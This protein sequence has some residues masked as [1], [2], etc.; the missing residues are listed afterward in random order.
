MIDFRRAVLITATIIF[1]GVLYLGLNWIPIIGPLAVGFI[2]GY[3]IKEKPSTGFKAGVYSAAL[4]VIT[5]AVVFSRT[6]LFNPAETGMLTALLTTWILVIWNVV[7]ILI[8]GLGGLL[9]S[10]AGQAKRMFEG[11]T[12]GITTLPFGISFGVP[13][14]RKVIKL[15]PPPMDEYS[16]TK[17]MEEE[18]RIKFI[19]C[20]HCGLSNPDSSKNCENCGK[21]LK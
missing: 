13:K 2:V 17:T 20:P 4:G 6:G 7:G 1:G 18:K 3:I 14:P 11:I 21:K 16:K 15:R 19:I 5:L 10:L 8:A 12:S 9:G